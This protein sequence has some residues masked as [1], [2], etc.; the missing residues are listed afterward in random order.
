MK[1]RAQLLLLWW[2]REQAWW[3]TA[4]WGEGGVRMLVYDQL[5]LLMGQLPHSWASQPRP[6][7][8]QHH[9][10]QLGCRCSR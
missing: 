3:P 4:Q 7:Q 6:R 2:E 8:Q 9:Q 5:L 10:Q 1:K